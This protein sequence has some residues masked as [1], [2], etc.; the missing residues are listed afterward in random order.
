MRLISLIQFDRRRQVLGAAVWFISAVGCVAVVCAM[1]PESGPNRHDRGY[2]SR[3]GEA[4]RPAPSVARSNSR[5]AMVAQAVEE[6]DPR[7][8]A[9]GAP[10][11]LLGSGYLSAPRSSQRRAAS[12]NDTVWTNEMA[13]ADNVAPPRPPLLEELPSGVENR[14]LPLATPPADTAVPEPERFDRID[15]PT[16]WRLVMQANPRVAGAREALNEALALG[17]QANAIVL[18]NVNAGLMY[19]LHN[20][21]LQSSFGQ[22]RQLNEQSLFVG[23][24]ARTLA[25]ESNAIPAVQFFHHLGDVIFEPLAARQLIAVRRFDNTD[26]ANSILLEA[27]LL[28]LDLVSAEVR[29]EA[30]RQT[31]IETYGIARF[32][33]AFANVGQGLESNAERAHSEALLVQ[34]EVLRAEERVAVASAQ[35]ARVLN[36]EPSVRLR[37][38]PGPL[39]ALRIVDPAVPL[40]ELLELARRRHPLLASRS[41]AVDMAGTQLRK[42]QTR[43]LLPLVSFGYSA[44]GFGGT[45]NFIPNPPFTGLGSRA[46]FDVMAVWTLQSMG[47]GNV[48][49]I[50]QRRAVL[51][52]SV[53]DREGALNQIRNE[54]AETYAEANA[55]LRK[56]IVGRRQLDDAEQGFTRELKQLQAGAVEHPIEVLNSVELLAAARQELIQ[57]IIGYDRAQFRL[58]VA[59][60]L[61]PLRAG[62]SIAEPPPEI[63][64]IGPRRTPAQLEPP[65]PPRDGD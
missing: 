4:K 2:L 44:G 65:P 34:V 43:P 14:D 55:R 31:E 22:I 53:R 13:Q 25:A 7:R 29:L 23:G 48:A 12:V 18:P 64:A 33:R 58:F 59:T 45:G 47:L 3:R 11:A 39:T 27:T 62:R 54:V 63:D 10:P 6:L 16:A 49:T 30:I 57:A 17:Q 52:Q 32:T 46:D 36:I 26:T 61:S 1:P 9:D 40:G 28:Y 15:L 50:Q 41:A 51:N 20:G 24:G 19:H 56:I 35:L 5:G 42:E 37:T 21:A 38:A 8:A 60:G